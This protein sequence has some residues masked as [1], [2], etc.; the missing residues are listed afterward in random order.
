MSNIFEDAAK[1]NAVW[2][3]WDKG[4]NSALAA[5]AM[6]K[7]MAFVLMWKAPVRWI[8]ALSWGIPHEI[9]PAR[10]TAGVTLRLIQ[11]IQMDVHDHV[12]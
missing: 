10:S 4:P 5:E 3:L 12:G 1:N 2:Q 7:Q 11:S 6:T 8:R 9:M